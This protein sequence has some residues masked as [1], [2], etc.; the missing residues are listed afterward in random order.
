MEKPAELRLVILYDP[1]EEIYTVVEHNL[2]PQDAAA[3]VAAMRNDH[4]PAFTVEQTTRHREPEA[5]QCQ[6]CRRDVK[7][8]FAAWPRKPKGERNA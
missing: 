8:T 4:L 2:E 6:A 5:E 1:R 7:R 3:R